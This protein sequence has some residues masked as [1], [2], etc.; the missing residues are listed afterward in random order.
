LSQADLIFENANVITMDAG[1][2]YADIVAVTGDRITF[3]GSKDNIESF[4]GPGTRLIDCTGKTMVPGFIDAHCHLFALIRR[5]LTLDIGPEK[6]RSVSDIQNIIREKA[7][8]TPPGQWIQATGYHEFYLAEKRHPTRWELDEASTQHPVLLIH[9]SLHACVLNS[10]A[11]SLANINIATEEQ[12][13]TMIE[14]DRS[15]G[16]PNGL[17]HEMVGY[18]R[19]KIM[20]PVSPVDRNLG[21]SM[22]NKRYLTNGITSVQDTSYSSYLERWKVFRQLQRDGLFSFRIAMMAGLNNIAPFIDEGFTAGC[23][24]IYLRFLGIKIIPSESTG[25]LYPTQ[26][27]LNRI[28]LQNYRRDIPVA[29]HSVTR[30]MVAA[31]IT[32]FEKVREELPDNQLIYRIEHCSECTP[33]LVKRLKILKPVVVTQPPYIYYNGDRYLRTIPKSAHPWL[34]RFKTLLDI[35][36]TVAAGSDAPVVPDNPMTGIYAAVT[37]KTISDQVMTPEEIITARQALHMYTTAAAEAS[38]EKNIKG[39][40]SAGKLADLVILSD[41]P[42]KVHT[43]SLKDIKVE[44]TIIG[45]RVTWEA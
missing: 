39:S 23:G 5:L 7:A 13:G 31:A 2:P 17:L 26:E 24:D 45:G 42:L 35:G 22:A 4:T 33:E 11:L 36:L 44:M 28:V 9:R 18:I 6:A 41:N 20:P 34:Y 3:A 27:E 32:A 16:E 8:N 43:E 12:P 15:T 37:R 1:M 30:E 25:E 38:G 29:I 14:R 19:E 40:I 21:A 10:M